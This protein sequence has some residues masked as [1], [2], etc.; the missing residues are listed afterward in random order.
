M[1]EENGVSTLE[2]NEEF[3]RSSTFHGAALKGRSDIVRK[4]F[5]FF[6]AKFMFI[7]ASVDNLSARFTGTESLLKNKSVAEDQLA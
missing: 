4:Q 5:A 2:V 6:K 7:Q 1:K 3:E